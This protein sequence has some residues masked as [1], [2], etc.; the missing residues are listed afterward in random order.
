MFTQAPV[1]VLQLSVVQ[2]SPSLHVEH[3]EP[4][5]PHT[6]LDSD[7]SAVHVPEP[8]VPQPDEQHAPDSQRPLVQAVPFAVL[9]V[10]LQTPAL[11]HVEFDV[12]T[13]PSSQPAPVAAVD[14][15]VDPAHVSVVHGL[16][17]SQL[18]LE[19]QLKQKP[20]VQLADWHWSLAVHVP[21]VDFLVW[22]TPELQ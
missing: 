11:L 4:L 19:P 1:A 16:P 17:S 21:K 13:L 3:T 18:P 22:H 5:A 8:S 9:R 6:V 12:Q 2:L 7:A 20:K 14:W 15:H 10:P